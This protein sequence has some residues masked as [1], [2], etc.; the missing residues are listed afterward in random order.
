MQEMTSLLTPSNKKRPR[1]STNNTISNNTNYE[2]HESPIILPHPLPVAG[3]IINNITTNNT[4]NNNN[5]SEVYDNDNTIHFNNRSSVNN[6]TAT[7]TNNSN[8]NNTNVT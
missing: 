1:Y 8:L 5:S 4:N 3:G 7:P 6:I 2:Q